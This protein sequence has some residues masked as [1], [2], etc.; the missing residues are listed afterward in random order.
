MQQTI[1]QVRESFE[2]CPFYQY[3]GFEILE[4]EED[5]VLLKLSVDERFYN[6]NGTLHGGVHATMLDFI[7]GMLLRAVTK[8]NCVTTS[9][10][11][12]YYASISSGDIYAEAKILQLGYKTA[13]L[14]GEIRGLENR[15]LAKGMATFKI[16]RDK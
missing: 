5:H 11:T 4:F 10:T 13:F 8:T 3:M 6:T 2:E 1:E 14:E 12:H 9:L 15:L 7:Q 16:L